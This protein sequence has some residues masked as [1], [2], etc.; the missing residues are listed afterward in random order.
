VSGAALGVLTIVAGIWLIALEA[1]RRDARR[2]APRILASLMALGALAAISLEPTVPRR[3]IRSRAVLVTEGTPRGDARRIA[4]SVNASLVLSLD[5]SIPDLAALR[6]RHPSVGE[7]IITGWGLAADE[8]ARAG[9]LRLAS[10]VAPLP[11]GIRAANWP[12][13]I[14]LGEDAVIAGYVD[15]GSLVQL[16][17][18]GNTGDSVRAGRD[19]SFELR[20]APRAAGL[21][22]FI[23]RAGAAADTGAIDV[24]SRTPP[25]VLI[26]EGTPDFELAHLRRW[27]TRRGARLA[28]RSAISRDRSRTF[29]VNGAPA[30]GRTLTAELL[31]NFD[32]VVLDAG[33][34][35][36]LSRRELDE[37]RSAVTVHGLGVL[38]VGAATRITGLPAPPARI[39]GAAR[40]IR[41]RRAELEG[42]LSPPVGA[43]PMHLTPD[44]AGATVLE[45]PDGRAVASWQAAGLG[46]VGASTV[47]NPSRWLLEGEPAAYDRYWM[48]IL[49]SLERPHPAWRSPPALPGVAG[50]PYNLTWPGQLDTVVVLGPGEVDTLFPLP[51]PDSLT[52][53]ATFWPRTPGAY[54]AVG[55]GDTLRFQVSAPGSWKAARASANASAT[56]G[57]AGAPREA[58]AQPDS[59]NRVP[60]PPWIFL[61]V[62]TG[63]AGWLWWERR[64]SLG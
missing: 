18:G 43:E 60:V 32:V 45:E 47:R 16:T 8:L 38:L 19:G 57:Y 54:R 48:S 25:A 29:T 26:L 15:P 13:R 40:V 1:R 63:S 23:L 61:A 5:E 30:P 7:V 33:A 53:T 14:V 59:R 17:A 22:T 62:F 20:L 10:V 44:A 64:R 46:R 6:R 36:G 4:D 52:W 34:A 56:R 11:P 24:R 50:R 2:L 41:V 28:M 27:L 12:S 9:D 51:D 37:L 21:Q 3:T 42:Q 35:R 58:L 55:A 31:R 49:A 39:S